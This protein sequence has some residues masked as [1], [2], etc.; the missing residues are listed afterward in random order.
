MKL[1]SKI[2]GVINGGQFLAEGLGNWDGK[3]CFGRIEFDRPLVNASPMLCSTWHCNNHRVLAVWSDSADKTLTPFAEL[4]D[5]GVKLV[6][7][8]LAIYPDW[9]GQIEMVATIW[10]ENGVQFVEQVR[11]GNYYGPVDI[12]KQFGYEQAYRLES[13]G[14]VCGDYTRVLQR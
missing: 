10:R 7:K 1:R 4:L 2:A 13:P 3:T 14:S 9:D 6:V 11:L 8:S 5:N 12:V